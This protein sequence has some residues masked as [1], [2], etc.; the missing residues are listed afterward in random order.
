MGGGGWRALGRDTYQLWFFF[1]VTKV[2]M[3]GAQSVL[4]GDSVNKQPKF[5]VESQ[6]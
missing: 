2:K 1:K 3:V 6:V 5:D 4:N